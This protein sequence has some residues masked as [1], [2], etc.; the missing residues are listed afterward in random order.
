MDAERGVARADCLGAVIPRGRI[1][2][3]EEMDER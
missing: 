2:D 1:R 3:A